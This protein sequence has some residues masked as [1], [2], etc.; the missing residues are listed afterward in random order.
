MERLEFRA[1]GCH[2]LAVVDSDDPS[3]SAGIKQV[4]VWFEKWEQVL[5]RFRPNSEL[6]A[7][8]RAA[9]QSFKVSGTLFE[10]VKQSLIAAK[11]SG[12]IVTPAVLDALEAAGYDKSFELL[13]ES[14][15]EESNVRARIGDWRACK[16]DAV[17]Q[18]IKL[19]IGMRLDLGG[20][21]KGWAADQA[22]KRLSEFGPTLIDA[23]GDVAVSGPRHGRGT[24]SVGYVD[25]SIEPPWAST[26]ATPAFACC[27]PGWTDS[28][29]GRRWRTRP[30]APWIS[31]T[32]SFVVTRR[33]SCSPMR[34]CAPL[35]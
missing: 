23:G 28:W 13:S 29:L 10:V 21:A 6:N 8:N 32:S 17:R 16:L 11:T 3:A 30:R 4:P 26:A 33:V 7:L 20:I 9:G 19:P 2:M 24:G 18:T 22:V 25:T 15:S 1:M 27:L 35:V 31:N 12:G 34:C 5:S 14:H